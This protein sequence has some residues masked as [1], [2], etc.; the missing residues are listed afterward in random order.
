MERP[1]S[2]N[3]LPPGV[4]TTITA[5]GGRFRYRVHAYRALGHG[6]AIEVVRLGL[7]L[8]WIVEP[9]AGAE[10]VLYTSVGAS[11]KV[12]KLQPALA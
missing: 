5:V 7:R 6:E 12:Q 11:D 9:P 2:N 4:A 1:R 3:H 10:T 8:G